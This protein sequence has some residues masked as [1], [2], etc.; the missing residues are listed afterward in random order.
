M[1]NELIEANQPQ[2][3]SDTPTSA[4]VV[5]TPVVIWKTEG[6]TD[7][8]TLLSL[9]LPENHRVV[10]NVFGAGESPNPSDGSKL[11]ILE[12]FRGK[13][14]YVVHDCDAPGQMGAM[15]L[16]KLVNGGFKMGW[17]HAIAMVAAEVRNV[18]LPY[19]IEATHGKDLRDW[20][21]DR[22]ELHESLG[23][24]DETARKVTFSEL[25]E[26]A[27]SAE[28]VPNPDTDRTMILAELPPAGEYA[29]SVDPDE[30]DDGDDDEMQV[31]LEAVDDPH[32]LARVN[33]EMYESSFGRRLRYYQDAFY[34]WKQT[35]YV[36]TTVEYVRSMVNKA[37]KEEFD[38]HWAIETEAYN[39][40]KNGDN[41]DEAKDKGAP[42]ARKVSSALVHNVLEAT[43]S[44]VTI[45]NSVEMPCW[46]VDRSSPHLLGMQNGLLNLDEVAMELA[47]G[48]NASD[49]ELTDKILL[50]HSPD[51]FS[52]LCLNYEYV[53]NAMATEWLKY[54]ETVMQGDK[55]RIAVLQEW[56][57]YL[58]T[59]TDDLQKFLC[60]EGDGGNGKTV[61][62]AGLEAM[63][64]SKNVSHVPLECFSRPFDLA[65]TIG[66][67]ANIVG[68]IGEIDGVAEGVLKRYTGGDALHLDRKGIDA[69]E[70]RPTAKLMFAWN[71]RPNFRDRTD[72]VWRRMI[73]VPFDFKVPK[74]KRITGMDKPHWWVENG[75]APG[76]LNWAL[77]GLQRLKEN[78]DFTISAKCIAAIED[79]RREANPAGEYITENMRIAEL[80]PEQ[81]FITS[82][83]IYEGYVDW[84]RR[85]GFHP[86]G[87]PKFFREFK[88]KFPSAER[89]RPR[90]GI[91]RSY[92]YEGIKFLD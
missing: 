91:D 26:L 47:F 48:K 20:A 84:C 9:P 43:K 30:S 40:W 77:D 12:R 62:L 17:A 4:D 90:D 24:D 25:L 92:G 46:L 33:L 49:I 1:N 50:S 7:M 88:K 69:I 76:I 21:L 81:Y 51:W 78:H 68:D 73:L 5:S 2:L 27:E 79:Y 57:G 70:V 54:I 64:G 44:I 52:T 41:Y 61:F 83:K 63:V 29:E 67:V 65:S 23:L 36:K 85:M 80:T 82:E 75:E 38:R 66:K 18:V 86:L 31:V 14:V 55:E 37:T 53:P 72:G 59:A 15:R 32:R 16:E 35:H 11:W 71:S 19:G 74:E 6:P 58:L 10:T 34:L 56:A 22:M 8:L 87:S 45:P 39:A 42:V 13:I 28:I 89:K 3:S 60:L